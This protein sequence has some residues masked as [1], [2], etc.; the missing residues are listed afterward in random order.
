MH[1]LQLILVTRPLVKVTIGIANGSADYFYGIDPC[2]R[3][4]LPD[5]LA[6]S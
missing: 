2:L 6:I 1:E 3:A 5:T 4:T